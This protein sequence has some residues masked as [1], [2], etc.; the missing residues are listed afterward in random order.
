[1]NKKSSA[2][3]KKRTPNFR[4]RTSSK[5]KSFDP[6][7]HEARNDP[8]ALAKLK[9]LKRK[10]PAKYEQG[11]RKAICILQCGKTNKDLKKVVECLAS[12]ADI[13]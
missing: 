13:K 12:C 10:N 9:E 5:R 4:R 6:L 3:R 7:L 2:Q 11:K 1:M 8:V